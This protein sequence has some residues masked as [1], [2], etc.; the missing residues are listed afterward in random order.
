[1]QEH[2]IE[3]DLEL[4]YNNHYSLNVGTYLWNLYVY[5]HHSSREGHFS[6]EGYPLES[7]Q[8]DTS[9]YET[10][11]TIFFSWKMTKRVKTTEIKK[12]YSVE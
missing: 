2:E 4:L 12:K 8:A 3:T 7:S 10:D 6:S 9:D 1:M 11:P 5:D